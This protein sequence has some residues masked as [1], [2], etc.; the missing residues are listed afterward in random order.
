MAAFSHEQ[1]LVCRHAPSNEQRDL[2]KVLRM[3]D[4]L[5]AEEVAARVHPRATA[6]G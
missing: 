3:G 5:D 6:Q 2:I 4:L 1:L